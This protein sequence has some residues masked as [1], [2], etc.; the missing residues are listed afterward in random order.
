MSNVYSLF[1]GKPVDQVKPKQPEFGPIETKLRIQAGRHLDAILEAGFDLSI[2]DKIAARYGDDQPRGGVIV[3]TLP[4]AKHAIDAYGRGC[5]HNCNGCSSKDNL[6]KHGYWN[7]PMPFPVN[8]IEI[9]RR[10]ERMRGKTMRL[11]LRSDPLMWMDRKYKWTQAILRLA[12]HYGVKL[13]VYTKSDLAAGDEYIPLLRGHKVVL[14][15]HNRLA[16]EEQARLEEPGVASILR[17]ERAFSRLRESG[18]QAR[19]RYSDMRRVSSK[20]VA[21][22]A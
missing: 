3:H 7:R 21:L 1:T 14:T 15:V 11:G 6:S 2:P 13:V 4:K 16:N 17:R 10:M 18:I 12:R 8:P 19:I 22:K 20:I 9:A 5:V